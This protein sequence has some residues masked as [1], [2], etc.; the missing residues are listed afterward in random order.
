MLH[1]HPL[2]QGKVLPGQHKDGKE[3]TDSQTIEM[4]HERQ[5]VIVARTTRIAT[6]TVGKNL[7]F[8]F[9]LEA[10]TTITEGFLRSLGFDGRRL[11]DL[12]IVPPTLV[13]ARA[14]VH[15]EGPAESENSIRRKLLNAFIERLKAKDFS[16][17]VRQQVGAHLARGPES[18]LRASAEP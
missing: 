1:E 18:R 10:T 17:V 13:L 6:P 5:M 15:R 16:A 12:G 8:T 2:A 11:L 7:S 3:S 9:T 14:G 4:S